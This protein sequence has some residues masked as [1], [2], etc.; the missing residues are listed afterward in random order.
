MEELPPRTELAE[1]GSTVLTDNE[2]QFFTG[3]YDPQGE[4]RTGVSAENTVITIDG[5]DIKNFANTDQAVTGS[6]TLPNGRH[7]IKVEI[8]DGFGNRASVTRTF[9]VKG[10]ANIPTVTLDTP[11]YALVGENYVVSVTSPNAGKI[12]SVTAQI[13]YGN[14]DLFDTDENGGK[15]AFNTCASLAYGSGF[16]GS[17]SAARRTTTEKTVTVNMNRT[18]SAGKDLFTFTMPMPAGATALDSLPISVTVTYTCDG[19]TYTT[20]TGSLRLPMQGYYTVTSD[21]M[22]EGAAAARLYVKDINGKAASG[23]DLYV[24]DTRIGTTNASGQ[25]STDYFNKLSAGSRTGVTARKDN[26]RSFETVIVTRRA[27]GSA[28]GMPSFV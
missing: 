12:D 8:M 15:G 25:V 14:V 3:Y 7:S 21:I 26:H 9:T 10:R 28:D 27:G 16:Q 13:V 2:L 5:Q 20:S 23:V 1:D 24:G 11:S 22:V 6:V 4:N 17:S 19:V 18:G